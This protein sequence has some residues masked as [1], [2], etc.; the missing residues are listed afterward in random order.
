[1]VLAAMLTLSLS[2]AAA[3]RDPLPVIRANSSKVSIQEGQAFM[4]DIWTLSPETKLDTYY[5]SLPRK[6]S[7]VTFITDVESISFDTE[8][9]NTYDFVILLD[10]KECH[11][12][13]STT[14][15]GVLTPQRV[16][17]ETTGEPDVIPFTMRGSRIYFEG[18]VNGNKPVA[19]QFDLGA[20][21]NCV[22]IDSVARTGVIFDGTIT[23]I[24]SSGANEEPRSSRNTIVIGNLKW[25]NVPLVQVRNMDRHED[26]IVGNTLFEKKVLE[27]DYDKKVMLVRDELD[28]PPSG[29]TS[30][31][32][33]LEQHRPLI[34]AAITVAD[35]S[36]SDWFLFD[37]GRDGTMVIGEEIARKHDLWDK[38]KTLMPLGGG[39]K[40]VVLQQAAL[41]GLTFKEI[42]TNAQD[43]S[44][45]TGRQSILGNELLNHFNVVLDNPNGMIYLKP[46]V[47]PNK[48]Y[49]T[50]SEF[51]R[52]VILWGGVAVAV[53]AVLGVGLI[54]LWKRPLRKHIVAAADP[55]TI[56]S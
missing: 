3:V 10:G 35:Q 31:D 49:S 25:E 14:Y 53:V 29:Y 45:H 2:A 36:Y 38:F 19:I 56:G 44:H 27:I 6:G 41:G 30:H 22:N 33:I 43:P 55:G 16:N 7:T 12:R 32:M 17:P 9:G 20:G 4:Q 46:N 5:V 40:V 21:A 24:N 37:T 23:V 48:T 15:R 47:L 39:R 52:T 8:F 42:V 54:K 50:Y 26:L 1:M 13:I 34:Q 51:K 11:T 18:T 28:S